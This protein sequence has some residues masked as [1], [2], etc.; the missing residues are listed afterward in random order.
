MRPCRLA[1][2]L[3]LLMCVLPIVLPASFAARTAQAEPRG[4]VVFSSDSL[5]ALRPSQVALLSTTFQQKERVPKPPPEQPRF[6]PDSSS[7]RS[8]SQG[9]DENS[10]FS[11]CV[12]DCFGN[13]IGS[14]CGGLMESRRSRDARSREV[15]AW[16]VNDHAALQA[17]MLPDSIALWERPG[18]GEERGSEVARLPHGRFVVIVEKQTE[19]SGLWLCVRPADRI[20]PIGWVPVSSVTLPSRA[21][22]LRP[23]PLP[24]MAASG[25]QIAAGGGGVGPAELNTEY[26]NGLFRAE[27]QYLRFHYRRPQ[28]GAGIGWRGAHGSPQVLYLTPT[29]MEEP[30][31]SRLWMLDFGF[32]VGQRFGSGSGVRFNWLL[33]PTL[34]YVHESADLRIYDATSGALILRRGERLGRWAQGG[35]LRLGIG[36]ATSSGLEIGL[37]ADAYVL[38]WRGQGV[39]SLS[40]D[41]VNKQIHGF[42]FAL[43]LTFPG[44]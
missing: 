6:K 24:D 25:W 44:R 37:V 8:Y 13:L 1:K 42:D 23:R 17:T 39:R 9:E 15:V 10:A 29:T 40:T 38:G 26:R 4:V 27:L 19:S 43:A 7:S 12:V 32:R 35:D 31:R 41:F 5:A 16:F 3:H 14:I 2:V 28:W 30:A 20:A 22:R 36:R 34:V 33:G 21:S 18:V 11:D